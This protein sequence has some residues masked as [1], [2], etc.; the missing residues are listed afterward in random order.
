[1]KLEIKAEL[2]GEEILKTFADIL[3]NNNIKID[4]LDNFKI[5]VKSKENKDLEISP[6]RLKIVYSK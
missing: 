3:T 2:S 1:M 6:E 5:I 4:N